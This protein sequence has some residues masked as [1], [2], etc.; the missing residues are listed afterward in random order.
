MKSSLWYS[1]AL[2]LC[3]ILVPAFLVHAQSDLPIDER[4]ALV[5][6]KI[7]GGFV[8]G[9]LT[10]SEYSKLKPRISVVKYKRAKIEK[11][12]ATHQ[13]YKD[14][15]RYLYGLEKDTDRLLNSLKRR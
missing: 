6:K 1:L 7:E 2:C 4:I 15:D 12:G 9:D 14:L 13:T 3:I 10:K 5:E 8:R 11:D